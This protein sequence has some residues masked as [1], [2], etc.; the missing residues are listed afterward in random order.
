VVEGGAQADQRDGDEEDE[1]RPGV[2][3]LGEDVAAHPTGRHEDPERSD[4]GEARVR[5][6]V[7]EI[8]DADEGAG[9]GKPVVFRV[10]RDGVQGKDPDEAED[11]QR[12]Q[13][14][15]A[16][17]KIPIARP[18]HGLPSINMRTRRALECRAGRA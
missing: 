11:E 5:R 10:L 14:R 9:V 1:I 4:H 2:G 15:D 17:P 12:D 3:W 7:V 18:V 6:H 8:R 16:L 13:N